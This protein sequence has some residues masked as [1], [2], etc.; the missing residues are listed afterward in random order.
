MPWGQN[1]IIHG[2]WSAHLLCDVWCNNSCIGCAPCTLHHFVG[3]S[4]LFVD[5]DSDTHSNRFVT[6]Q[7]N[8][9]RT[10][11][12]HT[13]SVVLFLHL[14]ARQSTRSTSPIHHSA[15]LCARNQ[16]ITTF[17]STTSVVGWHI[18]FRVENRGE[19]IELDLVKLLCRIAQCR[20][21]VHVLVHLCV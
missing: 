18:L 3:T 13:H 9:L 19:W 21:R 7:H 15:I 8:L 14:F 1:R 20:R 10:Q 11:H 2:N 16:S 4:P 12:T 17:P 6:F 5:S